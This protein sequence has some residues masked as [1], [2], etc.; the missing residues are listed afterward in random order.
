M[1]GIKLLSKLRNNRSSNAE[2]DAGNGVL[3]S[4]S[5]PT[6]NWLHMVDSNW[7]DG[8]AL[9]DSLESIMEGIAL[10]DS[11]SS[12]SRLDSQEPPLDLPPS[13][14]ATY[15]TIIQQCNDVQDQIDA[16]ATYNISCHAHGDAHEEQ[17]RTLIKRRAEL[18]KQLYT[19]ERARGTAFPGFLS[20]DFPSSSASPPSPLP[21]DLS[22]YWPGHPGYFGDHVDPRKAEQLARRQVDLHLS[23]LRTGG[24]PSGS[25][26]VQSWRHRTKPHT[27]MDDDNSQL[28][29]PEPE[30]TTF[31]N[32]THPHGDPV[33][34]SS[35]DNAHELSENCVSLR[36]FASEYNLQSVIAENYGVDSRADSGMSLNDGSSNGESSWKDKGKGRATESNVAPTVPRLL[37]MGSDKSSVEWHDALQTPHG[38]HQ[39]H[40]NTQEAHE[41]GQQSK[42]D[43]QHHPHEDMLCFGVEENLILV[44]RLRDCAICAETKTIF[45][46][47]PKPTT[48]SCTHQVNTCK[49]CVSSWL[50]S[51][52]D[53]K[54]HA[55][56]QC[57]ECAS[58][59]SHEDVRRAASP[60]TFALYDRRAAHAAFADLPE[61]AWCLA[62]GCGSGQM[63]A[64]A[65]HENFMRCVA[66][67]YQQCLHHRM[68][69]HHGETCEQYDYRV[70]GQKANDEE[71]MTQAVIDDFSKICPGLRCG[72]RIEKLEG[73][74]Q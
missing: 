50:A 1:P 56:L 51:E 32:L 44:P 45:D 24:F 43:L 29:R 22:L 53:D 54:G 59:L 58:Q 48:S 42:D 23:R 46:F 13:Y 15:E 10:V 26:T 35:R 68:E 2:R 36:S 25:A 66:C 60:E 16:E 40:S 34:G 7:S 63:N 3:Q 19:F 30:Q 4:S 21:R 55:H 61:F 64:E 27:S 20:R 33:I 31:A 28:D 9:D 39:E 12:S 49:A 57:P 6:P 8:W 74:D 73:C 38:Q 18:Q 52:L 72:W 62:Q 17:L 5:S 70:S 37:S 11:D 69:W 67:D 14:G 47:S 41:Q 71:K 65:Q